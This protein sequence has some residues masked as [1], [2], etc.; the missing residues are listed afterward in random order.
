MKLLDEQHKGEL[1]YCSIGNN[2]VYLV[3]FCDQTA[4]ALVVEDAEEVH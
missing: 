3:K 4:F 2:S 1:R